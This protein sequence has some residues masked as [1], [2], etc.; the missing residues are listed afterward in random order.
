MMRVSIIC[1]PSVASAIGDSECAILY[2]A[3]GCRS[4]M[5]GVLDTQCCRIDIMPNNAACA[6]RAAGPVVLVTDKYG[7]MLHIEA[8][9]I[10][11]IEE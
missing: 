10:R 7:R 6:G 8:Q 11:K 3:L 4:A 5:I 9:D 1:T 2:A